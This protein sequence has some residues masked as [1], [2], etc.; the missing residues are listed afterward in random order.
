M[1]SSPGWSLAR[2]IGFRFAFAFGVLLIYPF[3]INLIPE[4]GRLEAA[5][6]KPLEAGTSWL[7]ETVLGLPAPPSEFNASGDRTFDYVQLLLIAILAVLGAVVWTLADRRRRAYPGLAAG[8]LVVLRYFLA[9]AMLV[10]GFLKIMRLQ[11]PELD[12]Y[13]FDEPIGE[14]SP[15]GLLW[16]F[17]ASSKPYTIIAGVSEAIGGVLLLWRRTA[18]LGALVVIPVMTNVVLLNYCYDVPV[19][20]YSTGLLILAIVIASPSLRRLLGAALG[21]A[22]PEVPPWAGRIAARGPRRSTA[23]GGSPRS[24]PTASS[25]RR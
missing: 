21:R 10:Y 15:M 3:P 8:L 18:T 7:A 25:I 17:M 24:S 16:T 12:P 23:R 4:A 19:K 1:T 14:L 13:R 11:F 20:L 6:N 2:R 22:T 5:M 9:H